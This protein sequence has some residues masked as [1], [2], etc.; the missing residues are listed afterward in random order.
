[1]I[2]NLLHKFI[3]WYLRHICGGAAH[4]Y[5]YGEQ[6]RYLVIMDDDTYHRFTVL[7]KERKPEE[8]H[9][10][11]WALRDAGVWVP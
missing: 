11:V 5:S 8:F 1:M 7:A 10:M 6:G 9:K 4:C 2:K 3:A